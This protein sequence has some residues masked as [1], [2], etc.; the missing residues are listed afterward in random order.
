MTR[1]DWSWFLGVLLLFWLAGG[2]VVRPVIEQALADRARA[3]L[4]D[5]QGVEVSFRG[6]QARL[7]GKVRWESERRQAEEEIKNH[8]RASLPVSAGLG[9]GL[10]PVTDVVN[11]IDV[12]PMEPGWMVLLADGSG[13]TLLGTAATPEE[14]RDLSEAVRRRWETLGGSLKT[15]VGDEL[16]RFDEA[17]SIE[18]TLASVPR[19][20]RTDDPDARCQCW[21]VR[22]GRSWERWSLNA[23]EAVLKRDAQSL[24]VS[25]AE[26]SAR[27]WPAITAMRQRR[28]AEKARLAEERRLA[29]LPPPHMIAAF[30]RD[31]LLL[32]G[33][34]GSPGTKTAFLASVVDTLPGVRVLDDIRVS[35]TRRPGVDWGVPGRSGDAGETSVQYALTGSR[36]TPLQDGQAIEPIPDGVNAGDIAADLRVVREWLAGGNAGIPSLPAPPQPAFLTLAIFADRVLLAGQIAEEA[37]RSHLVEKA[38]QVYGTHREV[39]SDGLLVRGNCEASPAILHTA[40]SF[41]TPADGVLAVAKP[42]QEWR[43]IPLDDPVRRRRRID[44]DQLPA[45]LPAEG[46]AA[47]LAPAF[48]RWAAVAP[49]PQPQPAQER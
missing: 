17:S 11:A 1:K 39:Q 29:G 5:F 20:L 27:L 40:L 2:W 26:W 34:V 16:A 38:G 18:R 10:N 43:I 7:T 28:D 23:A 31:R 4:A 44:P 46:V 25:E 13:A 14:A 6:Q 33:E 32:R 45:G 12:V 3:E 36:W 42:G 19:P 15:Q 8:V 49:G 22:L 48:E 41:P 21:G 9:G 37:H 24:G 35:G 30:S 47:A